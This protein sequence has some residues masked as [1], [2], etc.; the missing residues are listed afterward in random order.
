MLSRSRDQS[1]ATLVCAAPPAASSALAK[2]SDSVRTLW[3]MCWAGEQQAQRLSRTASAHG[4]SW[5]HSGWTSW[6]MR[7]WC[8]PWR[9]TIPPAHTRLRALLSASEPDPLRVMLVCHRPGAKDWVIAPR[10]GHEEKTLGDAARQESS[11][12][13]REAV[14]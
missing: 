4:L 1:L 9:S 6:R 3:A 11:H 13:A 2:E 7:A 10:S 8:V 14:T 5:A 12:S